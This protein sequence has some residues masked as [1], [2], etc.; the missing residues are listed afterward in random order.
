MSDTAV[1][2]YI[3]PRTH[4]HSTVD[5]APESHRSALLVLARYRA[6][7][8]CESAL[9]MHMRVL[10]ID[11]GGTHV[12]VLATGHQEAIKIPPVPT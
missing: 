4:E 8:I 2:V 12:K 1:G 10:V 6:V 5:C 3:R 11:V 9:R 7:H